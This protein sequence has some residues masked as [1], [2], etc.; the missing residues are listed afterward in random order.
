MISAFGRWWR[1]RQRRTDLEVLWPA[2]KEDADSL[3]VAR[4]AFRMHCITDPAWNKDMDLI[5]IEL[6]VG[7][8]T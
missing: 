4:S 8:L 1:K 6:V 2:C 5:E 7:R 3:Y